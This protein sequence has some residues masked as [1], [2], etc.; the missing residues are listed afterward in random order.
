ML[1][2]TSTLCISNQY[3]NLRRCLVT[4]K[5]HQFISP[6]RTRCFLVNQ[7]VQCDIFVG[8]ETVT[9]IVFVTELLYLEQH[10]IR[11][12]SIQNDKVKKSSIA[13]PQKEKE[14]P[15]LP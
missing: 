7:Y 11:T 3:R 10:C 5:C 2:L 8:I 13:L 15:I 4:N 9:I 12:Y 14:T 6:R 1:K